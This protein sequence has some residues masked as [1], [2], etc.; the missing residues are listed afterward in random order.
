MKVK[1]KINKYDGFVLTNYLN[2]EDNSFI[3]A[4]SAYEEKDLNILINKKKY[5]ISRRVC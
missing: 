5:I 2:R 1:K 4:I 3:N